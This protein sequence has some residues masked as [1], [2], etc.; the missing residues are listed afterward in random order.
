MKP[1]NL[2]MATLDKHVA[3]SRLAWARLSSQAECAPAGT[4]SSIAHLH[5]VKRTD[6]AYRTWQDWLQ[7]RENTAN[8]M[9][10]EG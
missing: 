4:R 1:N 5:L 3:D 10:K 9:E 6:L 2:V 7:I 8:E